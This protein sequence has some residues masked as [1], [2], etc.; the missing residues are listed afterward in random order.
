MLPYLSSQDSKKAL[1]MQD[2][3]NPSLQMDIKHIIDVL[4]VYSPSFTGTHDLTRKVGKDCKVLPIFTS[5]DDLHTASLLARVYRRF[6]WLENT[7]FNGSAEEFMV[8]LKNALAHFPKNVS[9][10]FLYYFGFVDGIKHTYY[11]TGVVCGGVTKSCIESRIQKAFYG[12]D[13]QR[14]LFLCKTFKPT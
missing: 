3:S 5:W 14:D 13:K 1:E 2:F 12:L 4:Y 8:S 6:W 10:T 11:E 7:A 9:D